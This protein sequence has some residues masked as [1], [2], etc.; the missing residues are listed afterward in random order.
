MADVVMDQHCHLF[1]LARFLM[2]DVKMAKAIRSS[3]SHDAR[4]YVV[5]VEFQS[6]AVGTLNFSSGQIAEKEFIYF[7]ITG[8]GTFLHSHGCEKLM[9]YRPAKAP[10]WKEPQADY[11]FGRG[12]YGGQVTLETLG[13]VA[14]VANFIAAVKGEAEDLSPIG[15][16]VGTMELCEEVLRQIER[17]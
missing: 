2:G 14:D 3:R 8:K 4:D 16:A 10:W 6:G 5:A 13:Y 12:V 17:E 1:D 9:W 7:E 15:S 11:V